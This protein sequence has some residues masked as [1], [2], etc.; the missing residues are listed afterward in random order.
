MTEPKTD[1]RCALAKVQ[2]VVSLLTCALMLLAVAVHRDGRALG[3]D[4]K[5]AAVDEAAPVSMAADGA[6]VVNTTTLAA[7]ITGYG[8]PVPLEII[9]RDGRIADIT[10]LRNAESPDFFKKL[11]EAGIY[12][13]WIGRT[14]D[15]AM[16]EQVDG[17][18]GATY[19]SQAVIG[20]VRRAMAYVAEHEQAG[21]AS[22]GGTGSTEGAFWRSPKA[23][24]ALAVVLLGAVVPLFVRSP[25]Y[26]LVQLVLNV[27]VLGAWT[28]SFVSY[29]LLVSFFSNGLNLMTSAVA[30]LMLV[31]A[32]V[33][34][35]FGRKNHYCAWVCPL[36]SLQEL[37]GKTTRRKWALS[38]AALK[39]LNRLR[40]W[41]WYVLMLLMWTG[42]CFSWID[43]E[44][45][46]AFL[47]GEAAVGVV[48]A[49]VLLVVLSCFVTRPY[50]RF[51][52]PTGTLMRISQQTK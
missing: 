29:T 24:C 22:V 38:P 23:L 47:F 1:K 9:L 7:D 51:V 6:M 17:V 16:A 41:L 15:E 11:E 5:P 44:L 35:L 39:W 46:T 21:A 20:T 4:V 37:A 19:S 49:A 13:R 43:Y 26:R 52:C 32:F 42:L 33:F 3:Y 25:R 31:V 10:P 14:V 34:P 27:V 18:T 40:D 2:H 8:G 48:V 50:C 30:A 45:F 12:D 36:G 28:G